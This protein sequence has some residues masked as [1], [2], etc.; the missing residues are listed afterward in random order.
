MRLKGNRGNRHAVMSGD[1][2]V[3]VTNEELSSPQ[4]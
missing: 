1:A 3:S 4:D 2:S